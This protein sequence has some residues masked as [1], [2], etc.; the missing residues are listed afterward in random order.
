MHH[1]ILVDRL[2]IYFIWDAIQRGTFFKPSMPLRLVSLRTFVQWH[3]RCNR[4]HW[5][6][7]PLAKPHAKRLCEAHL[8]VSQREGN[9]KVFSNEN[10][11]DK[12]K[13]KKNS[14]LNARKKVG[15]NDFLRKILVLRMG[16]Q[17]FSVIRTSY[18]EEKH[19]KKSQL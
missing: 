14:I 19:L 12:R 2:C 11:M 3:S 8:L 7:D 13:K 5:I 9:G 6:Y 16:L 18:Y 1:C 10:P 15:K 17:T 4:C